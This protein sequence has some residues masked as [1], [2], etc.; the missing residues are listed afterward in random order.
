MRQLALSAEQRDFRQRVDERS[1]QEIL[2]CYQC[3]TCSSSCQ[4][5]DEMELMPNQI[6]NAIQMGDESVIHCNSAWVCV[7]CLSCTARCPK[8]LKIAETMEALR[9]L[10]LQKK[11]SFMDTEDIDREA[12][13]EIPQIAWVAAFRKFSG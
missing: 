4:F 3:G 5:A 8:N 12:F 13:D 11:R 10:F 2:R 9:V 7:S 1:G 6:M